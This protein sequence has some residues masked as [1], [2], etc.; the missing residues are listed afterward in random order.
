ML[1]LV[2]LST[3]ILTLSTNSSL[4]GTPRTLSARGPWEGGLSPHSLPPVLPTEPLEQTGLRNVLC[5]CA[6]GGP[7][8]TVPWDTASWTQ[9]LDSGTTDVSRCGRKLF[10]YKVCLRIYV[11]VTSCFSFLLCCS[12]KD[13]KVKKKK[14]KET[15]TYFWLHSETFF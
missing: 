14:K 6:R 9:P 5:V 4:T 15:N 13:L 3:P 2:C 7:Q 8:P 1:C 10:F 11:L 12:L